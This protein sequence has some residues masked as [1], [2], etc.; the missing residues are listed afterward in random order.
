[1]LL[2]AVA[3]LWTKGP[4]AVRPFLGGSVCPHFCSCGQ[5][6]CRCART[7]AAV[8]SPC[9]WSFFVM[10]PVVGV[11]KCAVY[12]RHP[13]VLARAATQRQPF[14]CGSLLIIFFCGAMVGPAWQWRAR[15]VPRAVSF[16]PTATVCVVTTS[17]N[18]YCSVGAGVTNATPVQTKNVPS[19][20][21]ARGATFDDAL[22]KHCPADTL[23]G[24]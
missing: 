1:M 5:S 7:V 19:A 3:V 13:V 2:L 6:V 22:T 4:R 18:M 20:G 9:D 21:V 10:Q 12:T 11:T 15:A 14:C 8:A 17:F 23:S 16:P 24:P